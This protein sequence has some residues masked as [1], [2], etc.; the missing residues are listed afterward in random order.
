M[1]DTVT[2]SFTLLRRV[3]QE[4]AERWSA[5]CQ[6]LDV[7]SQGDTRERAKVALK[8]AVELLV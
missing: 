8:E 4:D 2:I 6:R 7:C 5:G 1:A 3:H